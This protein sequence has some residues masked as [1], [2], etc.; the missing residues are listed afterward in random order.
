MEEEVVVEV[1]EEELS[2]SDIDKIAD[3][4]L[5]EEF[6]KFCIK[7]F[8]EEK[9]LIYRAKSEYE[10]QIKRSKELL[11]QDILWDRFCVINSPKDRY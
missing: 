4:E 3:R 5:K 1:E 10:N 8:K 9:T 7:R 6:K 2:L 11:T